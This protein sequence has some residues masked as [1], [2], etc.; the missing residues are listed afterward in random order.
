MRIPSNKICDITRFALNELSG[1]YPER[2]IKSLVNILI[3][4]FTGFALSTILAEPNK[5]VLESDLLKLNFAIK[6]LKKE[7][8]IQYI[9]G[10]TEF[11]GI[12]IRLKH[13]VLI[14]RPET[15]E[16]VDIII[17]EN[18]D[19][20]N[21]R[22][23]DLGTG[24]GAIALAIKKNIPYAEVLGFDISEDA[25][26]QSRENA[27]KLNLDVIFEE[28]NI[29]DNNFTKERFDIIVSNPP[30]VMEKEKAEIRNNVLEY[31]PH[32]ALFVSDNDP[33][34]YYKAIEI[35][36]KTNL[37]KGG[38]VYLEINEALGQ[39]TAEL[40]NCKTRIIKDIFDK[41]RIIVAN[42]E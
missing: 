23:A 22:I 27:T 21:L 6:D 15:E 41:D 24:S 35:F 2:E 18:K 25:L 26:L 34:Q 28:G 7:K 29:L 11:Y 17:K 31:E 1:I 32:L 5:T 39:E 9:I 38:K 42:Y 20:P 13:N 4:H 40:F 37:N 36:A 3:T 19:I 33:L 30:Y 10:E 16:L 8:P 12:K 14:P